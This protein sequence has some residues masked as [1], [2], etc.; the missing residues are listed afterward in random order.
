VKTA[1]QDPGWTTRNSGENVVFIADDA[2]VHLYVLKD[3]WIEV[4]IMNYGARI[5]SIRSSDHY[6]NTANIVLGYS[7]LDGYISDILSYLGAVVG[8]YSNTE[9][10]CLFKDVVNVMPPDSVAVDFVAANPGDSLMHCHQQLHMD[11][12]FMQLIR[13]PS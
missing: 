1:F 8:R 10:S 3:H 13:Y 7:G 12:G 4:A 5:V 6:G 2:P 9:M 11:F